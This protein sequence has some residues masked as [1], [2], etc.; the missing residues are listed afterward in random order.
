MPHRPQ[1]D[2]NL[3]NRLL[4]STVNPNFRRLILIMEIVSNYFIIDGKV[5]HARSFKL[6]SLTTSEPAISQKEVYRFIYF[7]FA[8]DERFKNNV[9]SSFKK[10]FANSPKLP[11]PRSLKHLSRCIIRDCLPSSPPMPTA[12]YQIELLPNCLKDYILFLTD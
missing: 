9:F 11:S 10:V 12:L 8:N 6:Y 4:H 3:L 2:Q 1:F 7:A 5:H